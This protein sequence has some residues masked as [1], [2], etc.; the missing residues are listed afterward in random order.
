MEFCN[1]CENI[2]DIKF[3]DN[4][5]INSCSCCPFVKELEYREEKIYFAKENELQ[6]LE[7]N[8]EKYASICEKE[9]SKCKN[10]KAAYY[11]LQTRSAD[12][13]M[14]IFYKCT[15]CKFVWKE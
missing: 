9:C 7:D 14:T 13:P 6:V 1:E 10:D 5:F 12:E 3:A 8:L 2:L 15:S 11:E 4:I